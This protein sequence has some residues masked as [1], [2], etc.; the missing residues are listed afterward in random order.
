MQAEDHSST[1]L[2]RKLVP[3]KLDPW[4]ERILGST[5]VYLKRCKENLIW[6]LKKSYMRA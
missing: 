2:V 1:A 5:E 6:G 3:S 4:K